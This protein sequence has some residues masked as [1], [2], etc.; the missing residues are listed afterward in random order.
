[1]N[2]NMNERKAFWH[3]LMTVGLAVLLMTSV[4][5]FLAE[6]N[7]QL[8]ELWP[9]MAVIFL[10]TG[11]IMLPFVY[12]RY[13][14]EP[15]PPLTPQKH[16]AQAIWQAVLAIAYLAICMMPGE[17]R[18]TRYTWMIVGLWLSSA[19]NHMRLAYKKE[20]MHP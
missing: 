15:R 8:A 7:S 10:V 19:L 6:L 1:M 20:E 5:L 18:I 17:K 12:R 4:L 11:L 16:R 2:Q 3:A 9:F 13:K 14:T